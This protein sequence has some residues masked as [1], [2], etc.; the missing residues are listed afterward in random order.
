MPHKLPT[1]PEPEIHHISPAEAVEHIQ[2]LLEA[3]QERVRQGPT[4]PGAVTTQPSPDTPDPHAP[5][6]AAGGG[7]SSEAAF[8]HALAHERG[9]Q[10]KRKG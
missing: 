7:L 10:S 3:K 1:L 5:M 4:W 6:P 9:D 2:A 8:G